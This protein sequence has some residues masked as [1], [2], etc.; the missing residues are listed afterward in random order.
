MS[1][2]SNQNKTKTG[3]HRLKKTVRSFLKSYPLKI[4]LG[5]AF[6][7][8]ALILNG[9]GVDH[10]ALWLFIAALVVSGIGVFVDAVKGIIRRDF[11]DEKFLM[12]IA[13]VG[14]MIIGEYAEGVAVML[15]FQLG[16]W[17]E[18]IS[19]RRSRNSIRSLM[20]IR[21]DTAVV[22]R[23]GVETE[24]D[25]EDVEVGETIIIRSGERVPIDAVVLDGFCDIDTSALTGE[26]VPRAVAPGDTVSSGTVV[27]GGVITCKTVRAAD[28]SAAARVLELVENATERK[29]R[30]ENFITKF[31]RVYTP[32]VTALAVIMAVV[33]SVFGWLPVTESIYRALSFLVVSCPCALVISVPLAFFGGIGA[34]ASE[35]ILYKGGN[36]FSSIAG[37]KSFAFDKT[38]TLTRGTL[39]VKHVEAV[40]VGED[41]LLSIA[42]SCEYASNHPIAQCLN[43]AAKQI[44]PATE[45]R[46]IAGRGVTA[47]LN[48]TRVYVGNAALMR[49]CGV[50]VTEHEGVSA[51]Y[52]AENGK[53]LGAVLLADAVKAEAAA[54]LRDIKALGV[55]KT[56]MLSGDRQSIADAVGS[57]LGVDEIHGELLPEN[58]YELLENIISNGGG[59][60]YVGDGINDSPCLA[61]A[62]VGIA[63]GSMGADS[64]IEAADVVIMSDELTKIPTAVRIARKTLRISK[65]NI[66]FAIGVKVAI[67]ALVSVGIGGGLMWMAVFADVGVAVLAILNSMRTLISKKSKRKKT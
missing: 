27:V 31:S 54:A 40:G 9:L 65:E 41:E 25:A 39:S 45:I 7:I 14:A 34:A 26:S 8:P 63:M 51:V 18:H 29:S 11:L 56:Y 66:V 5:A 33:P 64:A 28:E 13:S 58:K 19:V 36:V 49:D 43:G 17:F 37:A 50:Q 46:E 2:S 61:R 3:N 35:G 59:V 12:T 10:V 48:G 16:E 20:E 60:A 30:E 67:M 57:E 38:G 6:F 44:Y 53:Y 24:E 21:P 52:V 55:E 47:V 4:A 32:T 22:I 23:N 42:A 1:M 62:D 15:F